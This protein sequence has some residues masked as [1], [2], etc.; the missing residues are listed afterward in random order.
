MAD[1]LKKSM[2]G[3]DG[4]FDE[5]RGSPFEIL[6]LQMQMYAEREEMKKLKKLHNDILNLKG[7]VT[8]PKVNAMIK[9]CGALIYL[10]EKNWEKAQA[11]L[12]DSFKSYQ[13]LANIKAKSMLKLLLVTSMV[14]GS[15]INPMSLSEAKVYQD[16]PDIGPIANLRKA[17]ENNQINQLKTLMA[18]KYKKLSEDKELKEYSFEFFKAIK[19]KIL[20]EKINSYTKVSLSYLA[21]DLGVSDAEVKALFVELILDE[22]ID[23]KI[24]ESTGFLELKASER[25]V[26][27]GRRYA[28]L[29]K[30]ANTLNSMFTS[31][32]DSVCS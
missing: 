11:D 28:S 12:L 31:I 19:Q 22:R 24:D 16:D 27:E 21:K 20:I 29:E 8:D 13:Q 25:N 4:T 1:D 10:K 9:E 18:S 6:A 3:E 14:G 23:G 15:E 26:L 30:M 7:I 2:V 5:K 17:Y 32:I